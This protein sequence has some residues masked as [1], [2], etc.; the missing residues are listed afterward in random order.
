MSGSRTWPHGQAN[1]ENCVSLHFTPAAN[2]ASIAAYG[3]LP[4][5]GPLAKL[6]G[7]TEPGIHLYASTSSVDESILQWMGCLLGVAPALEGF[8]PISLA[9][10]KGVQGGHSSPRRGGRSNQTTRPPATETA[11]QDPQPI[12]LLTVDLTSEE[13]ETTSGRRGRHTG[14]SGHVC[15]HPI[16]AARLELVT[17]A[18]ETVVMLDDLLQVHFQ[19]RRWAQELRADTESTWRESS[20]PDRYRLMVDAQLALATRKV[21]RTGSIVRADVAQASLF[22]GGMQAVPRV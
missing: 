4:A 14:E 18:F 22:G 16:G 9:P 21:S 1:R 17:P 12:A 2:L 19:R 15:R 10:A 3:L 5:V 13:I 8:G 20:L 6:D 11:P 7:E